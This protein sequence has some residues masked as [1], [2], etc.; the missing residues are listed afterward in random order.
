M[1][2]SSPFQYI[3]LDLIRDVKEKI[4]ICTIYDDL[5]VLVP[6]KVRYVILFFSFTALSRNE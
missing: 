1:N 5:S 6:N 2:F 3:Q 4:I